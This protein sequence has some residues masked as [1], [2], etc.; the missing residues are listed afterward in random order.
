MQCH[1]VF[2]FRCWNT[3]SV[4][5]FRAGT[6]YIRTFIESSRLTLDFMAMIENTKAW[7]EVSQVLAAVRK[8]GQDLRVNRTFACAD[9]LV[10][11][12]YTWFIVPTWYQN[13]AAVL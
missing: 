10:L 2:V 13:S 5:L 11:A 6:W 9:R 3:R 7:R 8:S 12:K 4:S 1:Y